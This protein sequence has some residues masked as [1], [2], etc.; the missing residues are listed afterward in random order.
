MHVL[1]FPVQ[2]MDPL[3]NEERISRFADDN[4]LHV[5]VEH[6]VI[7]VMFYCTLEDCLSELVILLVV[8]KL[9]VKSVFKFAT[10]STSSIEKY[11][12]GHTMVNNGQ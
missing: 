10:S 3:C 9:K 12:A 1:Y 5:M 6:I 8:Y 2:N 7:K 11:T 4:V